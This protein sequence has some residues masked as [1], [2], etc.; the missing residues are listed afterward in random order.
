MNTQELTEHLNDEVMQNWV[1]NPTTG[2]LISKE[3]LVHMNMCF[4]CQ[5]KAIITDMKKPNGQTSKMDQKKVKD[6][7]EYFQ[8]TPEDLK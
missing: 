8:I 2:N 1:D 6:F 3:Q 4:N 5:R 7:V